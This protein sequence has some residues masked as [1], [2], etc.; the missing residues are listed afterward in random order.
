MTTTDAILLNEWASRPIGKAARIAIAVTGLITST[1]VLLLATLG[2]D[3]AW[4]MV[5]SGVAL[6]ATSIRAASHPTMIRLITLAGAMVV[7]PIVGQII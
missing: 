4:V 7:I 2:S 6:A 1:L 5:L 3:A